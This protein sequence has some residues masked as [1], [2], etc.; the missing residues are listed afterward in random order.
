MLNKIFKI[1]L[2]IE[3]IF[4]NNSK[5]Q[6]KNWPC[7]CDNV[8]QTVSTHLT[9]PIRFLSLNC[10]QYLKPEIQYVYCHRSDV[11][12]N[13]CVCTEQ[14]FRMNFS[15]L[16]TSFLVLSLTEITFHFRRQLLTYPLPE[17]SYA[18]SAVTKQTERKINEHKIRMQSHSEETDFVHLQEERC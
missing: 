18:F 6:W 15:V 8:E 2:V 16:T 14:G 10:Q 5:S 4:C 12:K 7:S 17:Y 3:C 1:L 13:I 9:H 11:D